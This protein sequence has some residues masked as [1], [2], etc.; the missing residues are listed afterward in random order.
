M[1]YK[2]NGNSIA[3]AILDMINEASDTG[4]NLQMLSS[5]L[6]LYS[7]KLFS[8]SYR[9]MHQCTSSFFFTVWVSSMFLLFCIYSK[10]M[11]HCEWTSQTTALLSLLLQKQNSI[12]YQKY[13]LKIGDFRHWSWQMLGYF[14]LPP[15]IHALERP[16]IIELDNKNVSF[17][18]FLNKWLRWRNWNQST[19][20]VCVSFRCCWWVLFLLISWNLK[21]KPFL[22]VEKVL[23]V[24]TVSACLEVKLLDYWSLGCEFKSQV[25]QA[26]PEQD[27]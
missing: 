14:F 9:G 10:A 21:T 12:K 6:L 22:F 8:R 18:S 5:W 7:S 4:Q 24:V 15:T 2:S 1:Q 16:F 25:H 13:L 19:A 11:C 20:C 27:P 26:A 3:A 17:I 23:C